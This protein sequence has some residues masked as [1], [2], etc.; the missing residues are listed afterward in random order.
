M[1]RHLLHVPLVLA[2][3][4]LLSAPPLASRDRPT[5][6]DSPVQQKPPPT[7]T[8]TPPSPTS[9][10]PTATTV[11]V[12][13]RLQD[14]LDRGID[15]CRDKLK[16]QALDRLGD[17]FD[18]AV[19]GPTLDRLMD[20]GADDATIDQTSRA[21]DMTRGGLTRSAAGWLD[22]ILSGENALGSLPRSLN[23][24]FSA[25]TPPP[26]AAPGSDVDL[27]TPR[28]STRQSPRDI[29]ENGFDPS[30]VRLDWRALRGRCTFDN[31]DSFRFDVGLGASGF[32]GGDFGLRTPDLRYGLDLTYTLSSG[33]GRISGSVEGTLIGGSWDTT[34]TLDITLRF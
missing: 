25:P 8:A 15:L 26:A 22:A 6:R 31:G 10:T 7:R 23:Q 13:W 1:S 2:V 12:G 18:D 27:G 33:R 21:L 30:Q 32:L 17:A 29:L 19:N 28:P 4:F 20:L 5:P 3:L 9:P 24:G 34:A 14:A 11:P 16:D